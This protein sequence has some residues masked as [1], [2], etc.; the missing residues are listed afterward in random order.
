M[1]LPMD[2]PPDEIDPAAIF[3]AAAARHRSGKLPEALVG[4]DLVLSLRPDAAAAHLNRG[5]VL[6]DLGRQSEALE[7]YD[8][9]IALQP[10]YADAYNNRGN[11]LKDL[12]HLAEA[13]ESYDHAVALQP[14]HVGAH[15]N[16]GATLKDLGRMEDALASYDRV[17]DLAPSY[18]DAHNNRANILRVL[19]RPEQALASYDHAIALRPNYADAHNNRGGV[20]K[21]LGRLGDALASCDHAIALDPG[22]VGAHTRRGDILKD[23]GWTGEAVASYGRAATLQPN[24]DYII[25]RHLR[26]Q[27]KLCE[28]DGFDG[29]VA[30]IET[31]VLAGE[32]VVPPFDLLAISDSPQAQ[33]QAAE[34]Y[35]ASIPTPAP[36]AD[37]LPAWPR[38]ERIRLGY[39]SADFHAHATMHLMAE[40]FERHDRR[41][42]ELYAFSFG[43][44]R[45][46]KWRERAVKAFDRFIDVRFMSDHAIAAM[47]REMEIDIAVDLK[48]Y[49]TD[50]RP[51]IFACRAAPV[52]VNYLG[53]PGTLGAPY[54]D[55]I[56]ADRTLIPESDKKFYSEKIAF[57]PDSYMANCQTH[58]VAENAVDR[59]G[60][61][62]PDKAFVYCCF[63]NNHKITPAV[64]DVWMRILRR[65]DDGVL[66]LWVDDP[67]ARENLR[68]EATRR[69]VDADRLIFAN[70]L[71]IEE[72]LERLRLADLF[73]DTLP[74]N[75][76][77]TASDALRMGLPLL[78]CV[79]KSF[80]SRVAASLL[81]AVGLSEL[82]TTSLESYEA[83]AVALAKNPD[84]LS[85]IRRK[86]IANTSESS[87]FDSAKI[88]RLIE[89]LYMLMYERSQ[90]SLAPD[91]IYI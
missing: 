18:A 62:L 64:F 66:W 77:T 47:A 50:S 80:S 23:L 14:D 24:Q 4:Y 5:A 54:M 56:I 76:H 25:G 85:Q 39:F 83:I 31:W 38:H 29:Q 75:A 45:Q 46:D 40:L 28:W 32:A 49:T 51:G 37:A 89:Y 13:L 21:D 27:L 9:A 17:I 59:Q 35:V 58:D 69:G 15:M 86:L 53:Y 70:R 91:D 61:G 19:R 10:G 72:H 42:F 6:S 30:R 7:S 87:I 20:L 65:V 79:G 8:Q 43:P 84:M 78:T 2:S 52:Q 81:G 12:G 73:L 33:R 60:M 44:E 34:R 3:Q 55:Y 90:N 57:L 36:T 68:K 63:N 11:A 82:V 88:S 71:P 16:R 22:H 67:D 1:T 26:L 74:Y 48:G 41:R